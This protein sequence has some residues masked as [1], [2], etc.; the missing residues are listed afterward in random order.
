M[1]LA[2]SLFFSISPSAARGRVFAYLMLTMAPFAVVAPLLGPALD[3]R[4]GGRRTMM[5]LSASGRALVSISMANHLQ[6]AWIF[7]EA[8][9]LLV[10]SKA[11]MVTKSALVP[12]TVASE[13]ELVEANAR[14]AILSVI[15]GFIAALPGV[16]VL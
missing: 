2:G 4:R 8:F 9:A 1:A 14:L 6:S 11:H 3:R 12:T 15:A 16:A 10:M 5:I 13:S 7:P